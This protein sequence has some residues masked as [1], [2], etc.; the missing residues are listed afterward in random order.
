MQDYNR[1][2]SQSE[3]RSLVSVL[4]PTITSITPNSG[5]LGGL[6]PVTIAGTNFIAGSTVLSFSSTSIVGNSVSVVSATSMTA[7]FA[8]DP[9][10]S[11]G[12]LAVTVTTAFGTSNAVSFTV[13]TAVQPTL[14]SISPSSGVQGTTL[15][16]TFTG[17]GFIPGATA[18]V[19][20]ATGIVVTSVNVVTSNSLTAMIVPTG[21]A[22]SYA[23]AVATLGG[24]SGTASFT[25]N[26]NTLGPADLLAVTHLAGSPGGD[27]SFDGAGSAA[28]LSSPMGVWADASTIYVA[29][30]Y[31]NTIRQ[32]SR[33][34][35]VVTTLAGSPGQTG[36]QDGI[37]TAAQFDYPTAIWG[38]AINLYV[39][40][41]YN[42]AIRIVNRA[43]ASVTTLA[44]GNYGA[45]DGTGPAARFNGPQGIWG[46]GTT[47]YVADT[48]NDTIRKIV[49]ATG[50]V[51]TFAGLA[52]FQESWDG[53]GSGARFYYP[54]GIWGDG[55]NLFV[56][57]L[58]NSTIR[59][60][61]IN[62]AV[63]TT[64]AGSARIFG[65]VD[66]IGP[67]A[68]FNGPIGITG[69]GT[70]LYVTDVSNYTIR[71]VNIATSAVT[72]FAGMPLEGGA[73][74]GIGN[75]ARFSNADGIVAVGSDLF[76][77][78][79][80]NN[81]IR[82][83]AIPTA[84]VTTVAG[85]PG[86]PDYVD[87]PAA[88]ARFS[89][90]NSAWS[91]G[92][93]LYVVDTYNSVI[94]K[95]VLAT[96]SV[97]TFA[98][99][100]Q[101]FEPTGVWGDGTYLYVTE[102]LSHDIRKIALATGDVT[103][104][105]SS[106]DTYEGEGPQGIWGNTTDLY[107]A[108]ASA[109]VI[110]K[111]SKATGVFH[112]FAGSQGI[113]GYDDGVGNLARFNNPSGV[114][115]DGQNLYVGDTG[116]REIR[117]IVLSTAEVTTLAGSA[118]AEDAPRDGTGSDALFEYVHGVWGDGTN[119]YVAD[120]HAIRKI[121][122]ASG[123]VT[124]VAGVNE[125]EG[126]EDGVGP[127]ARFGAVTGLWG[128]G[129]TL[130]ATD[131][132]AIRRL[133]PG[134][135]P[136]PV[137][138]SLSPASGSPSATIS[139]TLTGQNFIPGSTAVL[140]SGTG[141]TVS[142]VTVTG[143]NTLLANF[144]IDASAT[145]SRS[146]T[147]TTAMGTSSSLTF[148]I[149]TLVAPTLT[150]IS[151]AAG[152][153]GTYVPVTLTGTNFIPGATTVVVNGLG[154]TPAQVSANSSTSITATLLIASSETPQGLRNVYVMT[155]AGTSGNIAFTVTGPADRF[156]LGGNAP[157]PGDW[158]QANNWSPSGVPTL[159]D[160]VVVP[161]TANQPVLLANA[162][163]GDVT[164]L[165]GATVG[166]STNTLTVN[167]NL[168]AS[169]QVSGTVAMTGSNKFI[170]GSV[171]NLTVT[172]SAV[173]TGNLTASGSVT[174]SGSLDLNGRTAAVGG[175][176]SSTGSGVLK[177]QSSNGVMTVNGN[178]TFNGG[179]E[180]TFLTAGVMYVKGNF[181]QSSS[182]AASFAASGTHR[183]VMNGGS[184]QTVSFANPASSNNSHFQNFEVAGTSN[185]TF[186]TN[187]FINGSF[188]LT[189][190]VTVFGDATVTVAGDYTYLPGSNDFIMN[191]LVSGT[192][193]SILF[194]DTFAT[195][196]SDSWGNEAG[197]WTASG[198][199]YSSQSPNNS[200]LTYTGLPYSVTDFTVDLDVN[201]VFDGGIWLRS[202][203][204]QNGVLLVTG[205]ASSSY[206]GLYWHTIVNG[207]VSAPTNIASFLF[208][209]YTNIHLK[210]KVSG[211][212]Y[213]V[214]LNGS[215]TPATTLTTASF[216]GGRV[217]LYSFSS[218]TF[219][220]VR[221]SAPVQSC[222]LV[223]TT[224][225]AFT[226]PFGVDLGINATG[227]VAQGFTPISSNLSSVDLFLTG[228]GSAPANTL[229]VHIL[230]GALNGPVIGSGTVAVPAG[231]NGS[232][233]SPV[234]LNARL[235]AT[236]NL[237]PGNSYFVQIDPDGGFYGVA[238][239][240]GNLYSRGQGYQGG[241]SIGG[242]DLGFRSYSQVC[243]SSF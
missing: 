3:I 226:G 17:T 109:H 221:L 205:G 133:V 157:N 10:A 197:N 123:V 203:N 120:Y 39:A 127:L 185:V 119:L 143:P 43:T 6:V 27:G 63:V 19:T 191:L 136:S 105:V 18:I 181:T 135:I 54:S 38:D 108:V 9:S 37:G 177:M 122:L 128:D 190:P 60:I 4:T 52:G 113:S 15:A 149:N 215:S 76:V 45:A 31:N 150:S 208:S 107:V 186:S 71:R 40:D 22:G 103:T 194:N 131:A 116:N 124:T 26:S 166:V 211:N 66:D 74:D 64:F 98:G 99:S 162:S 155:A 44:G 86:R 144:T 77:A 234:L 199:R 140:A 11:L 147:V 212:T 235:R 59:K 227:G 228:N 158:A 72:T 42:E 67:A 46:D 78:D 58:T 232:T 165:P 111:V 240:F 100:A 218:Q 85:A 21:L 164:V 206:S 50:Q 13:T 95:V 20:P 236:I 142:S 154:V 41:T 29:D 92:T 173:I 125:V 117:K 196:A 160:R 84:A 188:D 168:T 16:V 220:N 14:T 134:S 61:V 163:V 159:T 170:S 146:I 56:A 138:T 216:A 201:S 80:D 8:I 200:P 161:A 187:A 192:T 49:I 87:G 73:V 93:N 53:N 48:Y 153:E 126:S 214:Y 28:R 51:T 96:G 239:A 89:A 36:F 137:L 24:T 243:Q 47:L 129:S 110:L 169:G 68:L 88:S 171:N 69:D 23:L 219:S 139:I 79:Y 7:T 172:G 30:T 2:L 217:G 179:S 176:Y 224:D 183:V 210:I 222:N 75:A 112:V 151:P 225:Q 102:Q 204:N 114:W 148:T 12:S 238:S 230:S 145:G 174:V 231:L 97:T 167:G 83:I 1:P 106:T 182:N 62:G 81:V 229:N 184:A 104:L 202:S 33:S 233:S 213:S 34:T 65:S 198:G 90:P 5:P 195:V 152:S 156:W 118:F 121:V 70:N 209:T 32:I 91:D 132:I 57:D 35:G 101:F 223:E 115:G 130:Y 242:L 237:T 141:L 55:T 178:A 94:R 189:T 241:S 207:S 25:I 193:N 180:D 175:N 82:K